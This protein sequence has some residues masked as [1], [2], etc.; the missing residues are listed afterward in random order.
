MA[1]SDPGY[2][3]DPSA[4][5]NACG[6]DDPGKHVAD[7]G[8][9][10]RGVEDPVGGDADGDPVPLRGSVGEAGKADAPGTG[11]ARDRAPGTAGVSALDRALGSSMEDGSDVLVVAIGMLCEAIGPKF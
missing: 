10:V 2:T 3:E 5:V 7:L 4:A 1:A 9:V 6:A 8:D 11:S